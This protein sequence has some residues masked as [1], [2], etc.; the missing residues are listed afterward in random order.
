MFISASEGKYPE[1]DVAKLKSLFVKGQSLVIRCK[2]LDTLGVNLICVES[3]DLP[4]TPGQENQ[5]FS[6]SVLSDQ[7]FD[8]VI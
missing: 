7:D 2:L 6:I 8:L 3:I 5:A 4:A 1:S